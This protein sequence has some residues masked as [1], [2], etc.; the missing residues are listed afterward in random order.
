MRT[1]P[2]SF[3]G[4][5]IGFALAAAFLR[6]A[7]LHLLPSFGDGTFDYA[8]SL[9][10]N[11]AA[12]GY[13]QDFETSMPVVWSPVASAYPAGQALPL[14]A[15]AVGG[16][17]RW[18]SPD[19]AL[20]AG[21]VAK[22]F[23]DD[24]EP[25]YVPAVW[26]RSSSGTCTV[27]LLP[28]LGSG[29]SESTVTSGSAAGTRFAGQ[30]GA[31]PVAAVWCGT[32]SS[33]YTVQALAL[34]SDATGTSLASSMSS[35]GAKAVGHYETA[36][37]SQAAVWTESAGSYA[38]TKLQGLAGNAQSFAEVISRDG[39]LAGG[40]AHD[41]AAL[42][43]VTWNAATGAVTILETLPGFEATV[44]GIADNNFWLGGRATD[45]DTFESAAVLWNGEGRI[46]DLVALAADAG[47]SFAGFTP[48][49]VTGIHLVSTGL[50][51]IVGTGLNADGSTQGFVLQNLALATPPPAPEPPVVIPD[52]EPPVVVPVPD[53]VPTK[54]SKRRQPFT[55]SAPISKSP[56]RT[57]NAERPIGGGGA[58]PR[59]R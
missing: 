46:F 22:P 21:F 10:D 53:P 3:L 29:P 43:P 28:R 58:R 8:I 15:A 45:S 6:A 44:L 16:G 30:S 14:P 34:P 26:N 33:A 57:D 52:P 2:R 50:Y 13:S 32:V 23:T 31:T 11:G 37:G 48:E 18:I 4:A 1:N 51:T 55:N 42:R 47:I 20:L 25:D 9:A 24:G 7:S 49:S 59:S 12:A 41:A 38:V 27:V 40:A 35:D 19:A 56:G 36:T 54:I 5:V 39:T 17:S